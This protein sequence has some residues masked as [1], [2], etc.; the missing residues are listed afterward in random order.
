[1]KAQASHSM[2]I[3]SPYTALCPLHAPFKEL[4]KDPLK[5][6]IRGLDTENSF[7]A[8]TFCR[9]QTQLLEGA[10][11]AHPKLPDTVQ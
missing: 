2:A 8:K 11:P 5:G 6:T 4:L 1:M 10:I 7:K 3:D 9:A